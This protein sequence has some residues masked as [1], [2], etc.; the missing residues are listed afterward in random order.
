[1]KCRT[2]KVLH[3]RAAHSVIGRV[4]E[5]V[6]NALVS[7]AIYLQAALGRPGTHLRS[8]RPRCMK[9]NKSQRHVYKQ[10]ELN[11]LRGSIPDQSLVL[12]SVNFTPPEVAW[13]PVED[14]QATPARGSECSWK[15][16]RM[17]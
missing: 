17:H 10:T 13:L 8:Q 3:D 9:T 6:C 16:P 11:A 15:C 12:W 7:L 1:M 14:Y 4:E 5:P 2:S